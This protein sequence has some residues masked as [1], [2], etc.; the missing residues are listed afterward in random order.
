MDNNSMT[1]FN[2]LKKFILSWEGGFVNDPDDPGGA[3]NKGITLSKFR[4]IYGTN[5]TVRD[6]KKLTD[7]QWTYIFRTQFW[8][9][10]K[11]DDII[12]SNLIF[13]IVDWFWNSGNNCTKRV[14]KYLNVKVDGIVGNKT[15]SALNELNG[16]EA[17]N[18]IWHLRESYYKT[19][20]L[21]WKYGK[22]W[23]RRLNNIQYGKLINNK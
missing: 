14:Q 18:D 21:F 17:F 1:D 19:R 8:D 22:G 11:A 15:I 13:L 7:E 23:L 6:L 4:E 10:W 3:T 16:K 5:K 12:D 20:K 2:K 9:K